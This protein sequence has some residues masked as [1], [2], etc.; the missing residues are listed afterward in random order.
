ME[1]HFK[2]RNFLADLS[3]V[4][5]LRGEL[6]ARYRLTH[7]YSGAVTHFTFKLQPHPPLVLRHAF[8]AR[9][10]SPFI[11]QNGTSFLPFQPSLLL[12]KALTCVCVTLIQTMPAATRGPPPTQK[13]GVDICRLL[14]LVKNA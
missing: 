12:R 4:T 3:M 7:V 13:G 11:L 1:L 8:G 2:N 14:E 6:R 5:M 10:R 9:V